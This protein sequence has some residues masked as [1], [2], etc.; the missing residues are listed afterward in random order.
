M[1]KK[2]RPRW[3]LGC[4]ALKLNVVILPEKGEKV[5][6]YVKDIKTGILLLIA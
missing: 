3:E 5:I 1:K 2:I 6:M 4:T